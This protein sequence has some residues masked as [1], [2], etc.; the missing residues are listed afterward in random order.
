MDIYTHIKFESGE[1]ATWITLLYEN[2]MDVNPYTEL[3]RAINYYN[4]NGVWAISMEELVK[5]DTMREGLVTFVTKLY[6]CLAIL[7]ECDE[8]ELDVSVKAK[9]QSLDIYVC[10]KHSTEKWRKKK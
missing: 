5:N 4:G 3:E 2:N 9:S 7:M 8:T 6:K 10:N 1:E